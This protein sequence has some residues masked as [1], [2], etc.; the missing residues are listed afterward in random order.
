MVLREEG[1]EEAHVSVGGG[2]ALGMFFCR[3]IWRINDIEKM[4]LVK[5]IQSKRRTI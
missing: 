2:V 5:I 4:D 3:K 1:L